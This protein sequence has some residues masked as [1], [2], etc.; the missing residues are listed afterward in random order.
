MRHTALFVGSFNPSAVAVMRAWLAAGHRISAFW[1]GITPT[2]GP[3][4][5]DRRLS[6]VLPRWSV[7]ALAREHGFPVRDVPRLSA[8]PAAE[9]EVRATGADVLVSVYFPFVVPTGILEMFGPRALNFHP[10]P[11]P[12]YRGP[13]PTQAMVLDRS[14][15]TDAAMTLHVMTP[16]LDEG[17]IV[18][19]EPVHFPEDLCL[20]RYVLATAEAAGRLAR[21]QLPRYLAGE[22]PAVPQDAAEATYV[23]ITP[24]ELALSPELSADEIEWRCRTFAADR[25]LGIAG[26]DGVRVTGFVGI[27]GP[28]TGR[29]PEI[30]PLSVALDVAD[31]RVRLRRKLPL[32]RQVRRLRRFMLLARTPVG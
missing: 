32:A 14:I 19:R 17:P 2:M 29:A 22:L 5:R 31:A 26:L 13:S 7:T 11:L 27:L 23:R 3:V 8:W 1:R 16:G 20:D 18:A 15:L 24:A 28:A 21:E 9:D 6:F 10:A 30:G 4:R 12:R 25:T